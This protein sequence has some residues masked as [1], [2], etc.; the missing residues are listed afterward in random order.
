ME[1]SYAILFDRGGRFRTR[2]L[3]ARF[4]HEQ[5]HEPGSRAQTEPPRPVIYR[6]RL[7]AQELLEIAEEPDFVAAAEVMR[8]RLLAPITDRPVDGGV[9]AIGGRRQSW[10]IGAVGADR[11]KFTGAG[12]TVALLDT[13]IDAEHPAFR[14]VELVEKDFTGAGNGDGDEHG[15]HCAGII[16]GRNVEGIRIGVAPG[17][18]RALIGKVVERGGGDSDMLAR[19][20]AW[21]HEQ[22]AQIISMS[23][24]F[25]FAATVSDRVGQ[26]WS[27]DLAV[28]AALEA[29][30]ANLILLDR[31]LQLLKLQE[32]FTGGAIIVAAAGNESSHGGA[33]DFIIS[34]C[35]PSGTDN[36]IAVGSLD[37]GSGAGGYR[38][39]DFSNSGVAISA[40]GRGILSAAAGGH[41]KTLS[42]TSAAAPHVA[43]VA[44]LWWQATRQSQLPANATV[45]T[46]KLLGSAQTRCFSSAVYPSERGAGLAF[47]PRDGL[48]LSVANVNEGRA[49]QRRGLGWQRPGGVSAINTDFEPISI[50]PETIR[51][52]ASGGR[53]NLC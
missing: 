14:G 3:R 5:P 23:V 18:Q 52:V 19:G 37:P 4:H 46:A 44:A 13:G 6:E 53:R 49:V 26:G 29:Y 33:G 34:A 30:R 42:G 40:P 48:A 12:V 25:D 16:F 43:G 1:R 35:P 15:T 47:A 27:G 45:V 20:L 11:S 36:I 8:T 32:P 10:G 17:V 51:S 31:L 50:T 28:T 7:T 9:R 22:G 2:R 38:V 24:G 21:A 39:S 41:L